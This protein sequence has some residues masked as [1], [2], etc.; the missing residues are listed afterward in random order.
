[1]LAAGTGSRLVNN[2]PYYF[3]VT[4]YS[5][6]VLNTETFFV[7]PNPLGTVAEVLESA[8]N[9]VQ[10]IPRTRHLHGQRD[11]GSGR[12]R[13]HRWWRNSWIRT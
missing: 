4:A 13:R 12:S 9:P 8:L 2:K 10:A 5:F 3:A 7:G 1:V 11:P 6:D